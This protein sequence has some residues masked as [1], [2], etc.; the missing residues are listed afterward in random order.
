METEIV[1]DTTIDNTAQQLQAMGLSNDADGQLNLSTT[2]SYELKLKINEE[3]RR[4]KL[5]AT[6]DG[7]KELK[8]LI[9]SVSQ[10]DKFR[11]YLNDNLVADH[12][13]LQDLIPKLTLFQLNNITVDFVRDDPRITKL[14]KKIAAL[15]QRL[16]KLK[17]K[18]MKDI[19]TREKNKCKK[20][21]ARLTRAERLKGKMDRKERKTKPCKEF[22][23]K[24]LK[25]KSMLPPKSV[26]PDS[27]VVST[28][29]LKNSG[30]SSW[31]EG[32]IF[33]VTLP[34]KNSSATAEDIPLSRTVSPGEE[35]SLDFKSR[36]PNSQGCFRCFWQLETPSN[37]RVGPKLKHFYKVTELDSTEA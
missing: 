29:V 35:V 3:I 37:S 11:L 15:Q 8:E 1:I 19:K 18:P 34:R 21:Q 23:M 9:V 13:S 32:S 36:A 31:P 20:K 33:K 5:E 12:N 6:E 26:K 27:E 22:S 24:L 16:L 14:E 10:S 30:S 7:L 17:S 25:M 2:T 4:W 28:L